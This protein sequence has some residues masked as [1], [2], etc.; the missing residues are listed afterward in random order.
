MKGLFV[1]R[2][3]NWWASDHAERWASP[4]FV[5]FPDGRREEWRRLTPAMAAKLRGVAGAEEILRE[6]SRLTGRDRKDKMAQGD[7]GTGAKNPP[8]FRQDS[9]R[10]DLTK[11]LLET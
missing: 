6:F 7:A 8:T 1:T 4:H 11:S 10:G 3:L 2:D 9:S 5:T